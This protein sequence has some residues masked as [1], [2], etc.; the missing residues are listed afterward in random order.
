MRLLL[1]K[2][3]L[4]I[5]AVTKRSQIKAITIYTDKTKG[6]TKLSNYLAIPI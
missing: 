3:V 1:C 5:L 4:D 6:D 2:L